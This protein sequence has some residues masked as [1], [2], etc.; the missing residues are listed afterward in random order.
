MA[1]TKFEEATAIRSHYAN[2]FSQNSGVYR[3]WF[4]EKLLNNIPSSSINGKID[5]IFGKV[6]DAQGVTCQDAIEIR[7]NPF[8]NRRVQIR[9]FEGEYYVALYLGKSKNLRRRMQ[10]HFSSSLGKSVLRRTINDIFQ[11]NS[12][13]QAINDIINDIIDSCYVE[14]IDLCDECCATRVE[15]AELVYPSHYYPFNTENHLCHIRNFILC[16]CEPDC[17]HSIFSLI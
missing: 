8:L 17:Y 12:N 2:Y 11:L 4:P 5:E 10:D 13:T 6:E 3:W 15:L 1:K 9:K 16:S 14:W 7:N